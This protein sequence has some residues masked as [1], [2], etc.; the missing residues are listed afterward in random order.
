M[1]SKK[2]DLGGAENIARPAVSPGCARNWL[3]SISNSPW[4][5]WR[6]SSVFELHEVGLG[7]ADDQLANGAHGEGKDPS[8]VAA[9]I[10]AAAGHPSG[11]DRVPTARRCA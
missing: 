8:S 7:K 5:E 10:A 9:P 6:G 11:D 3:P 1:A 2:S 4:R